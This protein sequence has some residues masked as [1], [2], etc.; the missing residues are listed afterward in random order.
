MAFHS[1]FFDSRGLDRTY[2]AEDFTM[3]LSSFI[4]NGILDSYGDNFNLT[5]T[6]EGRQVIV[7]TGKAWINGHYFVID[8]PH[9][10]DFAGVA[11]FHIPTIYSYHNILRHF[12]KCAEC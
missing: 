11:R 3:Y 2:T 12:R 4:C 6:G 8:E 10:M 7:G 1:G 5:S 9:L